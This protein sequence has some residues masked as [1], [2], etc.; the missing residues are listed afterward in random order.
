MALKTEF[1]NKSYW[2]VIVRALTGAVIGAIPGVGYISATGETLA[3]S[4]FGVAL[5]LMGCIIGTLTLGLAAMTASIV[6]ALKSRGTGP[7]SN[8]LKD[9]TH[10]DTFPAIPPVSK[11]ASNKSDLDSPTEVL[12]AGAVTDI[13]PEVK[14]QVAASP[15]TPVF[16]DFDR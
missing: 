1:D 6:A 14:S 3:T 7:K 16:E 12:P 4:R 15:S 2:I 9:Y 13:K 10:P 5:L 8:R 11:P